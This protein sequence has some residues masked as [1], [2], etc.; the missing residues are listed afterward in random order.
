MRKTLHTSNPEISQ[1]LG[2]FFTALAFRLAEFFRPPEILSVNGPSSQ[3]KSSNLESIVK[4]VFY[5]PEMKQLAESVLKQIEAMPSTKWQKEIT[6]FL[7]QTM[8]LLAK[9]KSPP[10]AKKKIASLSDEE[11]ASLYLNILRVN[12][13]LAQFSSNIKHV[14]TSLLQQV[15]NEDPALQKDLAE[16]LK[17]LFSTEADRSRVMMMFALQA[18]GEPWAVVEILGAIEDVREKLISSPELAGAVEFIEAGQ[19]WGHSSRDEG[20]SLVWS[21][22]GGKIMARRREKGLKI[23]GIRTYHSNGR[24]WW[25]EEEAIAQTAV[26]SEITRRIT[27]K[28]LGILEDAYK[29]SLRNSLAKAAENDLRDEI[30]HARAK[31]RD[32]AKSVSLDALENSD[33]ESGNLDRMSVR[34]VAVSKM[35]DP[36][37]L[38]L[39]E[40][41]RDEFMRVL[42][43]DEKNVIDL[44]IIQGFKIGEVATSLKKS[45]AWVYKVKARALKKMKNGLGAT[46]V[47]KE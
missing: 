5:V 14:I 19:S 4:D 13:D 23:P 12:T 26:F 24:H 20:F 3:T 8:S 28:P 38:V 25:E 29:G 32:T 9:Q 37:D 18:L 16:L 46:R 31:K 7:S 17:G 35:E 21:G 22:V 30:R 42:T 45:H 1:K 34:N 11:R 43:E 10:G 36:A 47:E 44:N 41:V 6:R 27:E 15:V 2:A 33:G 40:I 39:D